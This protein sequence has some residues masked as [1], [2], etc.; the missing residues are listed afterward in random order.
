MPLKMY[1]APTASVDLGNGGG[2]IVLR[3]LTTNDIFLLFRDY[4]A[5]LAAFYDSLIALRKESGKTAE[6]ILVDM[7]AL[8]MSM[9][10]H[11]PH[12]A[13]HAI[14][15]AAGEPEEKDT[16]IA[17]RFPVQLEALEK[18]FVLTFSG[19]ESVKKVLEVV[20]RSASGTT[21][22]LKTLGED[23]PKPPRQS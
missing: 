9:L 14:A 17:L 5:E 2:P 21:R 6:Q 8:A 1:Q 20:I 10:E 23:S 18:I 3:A 13:G 16:A 22:L 4:K 7:P 19:A 15:L 12:V 11:I